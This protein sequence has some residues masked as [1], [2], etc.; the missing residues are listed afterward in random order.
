MLHGVQELLLLKATAIWVTA[1]HRSICP[2]PW[3]WTI[4]IVIQVNSGCGLA[5]AFAS[6]P[7]S[8]VGRA[9]LSDS[10]AAVPRF[11]LHSALVVLLWVEGRHAIDSLTRQSLLSVQVT[12]N[13]G[14]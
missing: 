10:T 13:S 3:T 1:V 9:V 4:F 11:W 14:F 7:P 12:Q 6:V 2:S 5:L 8:D